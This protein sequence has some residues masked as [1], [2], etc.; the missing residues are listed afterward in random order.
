[1]VIDLVG[2][3]GTTFSYATVASRV[4]EYLMANAK[5]GRIVNLDPGWHV[6]HERLRLHTEALANAQGS[7][8]FVIA[9]PEE[10]LTHFVRM[11]GRQ[12]AALFV[13]PN[14]DSFAPEHAEVCQAFGLAVAPSVWCAASVNVALL[15][16]DGGSGPTHVSVAPL[17]VDERLLEGRDA[18]IERLSTRVR[19]RPRVLHMSTDQLWP[20][21]KG[22]EAL[23]EA[24]WI[25]SHQSGGASADLVLHVPPALRAVALRMVRDL[26]IDES[27]EVMCGATYGEEGRSLLDAIQGADLVVAPS[28]CEGF[29]IMLLSTLVAGVP[30]LTTYV[31]GQRDF[32][33]LCGGWLGI[34]T[35]TSQP[36]VGEMG[37]APALDPRVLADH[38]RVALQPEVRLQLLD[39]LARGPGALGGSGAFGGSWEAY[40]W[41]VAAQM[42]GELLIEWFARED[43]TT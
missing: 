30:L 14:T 11:Y 6:A 13:S 39:T 23:L 28:R 35:D 20:G 36:L 32:L 19:S 34:P 7:H 10:Y 29:G 37:F 16:L 21:R 31:T 3:F 41:P 4:A 25:L 27:V 8:V 40:T 43:E 17:G 5:L 1:M 38:L 15:A 26:E 42:F 33:R 2:H 18:T 24:W 22:T 12:R 9:A